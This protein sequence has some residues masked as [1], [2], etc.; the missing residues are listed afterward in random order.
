VKY[1]FCESSAAGPLSPWHIRLLTSAGKKPSG[2]VDTESLC[3]HVT[4][5]FGGWDLQAEVVNYPLDRV[6]DGRRHVCKK[7]AD[8]YRAQISAG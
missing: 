8:L 3:G 2:G 7:C 4:R 5:K 6:T 1:S